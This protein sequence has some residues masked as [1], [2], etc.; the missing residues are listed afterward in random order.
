[1]WAKSPEP[2]E[3]DVKLLRNEHVAYPT[4][5]VFSYSNAAVTILGHALEKVGGSDFSSQL[6]ASLLQPLGMSHSIFD[7]APDH[8]P[9][10]A[11]A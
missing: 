9:L 3:N 4:N 6:T 5:Y 7:P 10:A 2:F 1:M 11:K 8:S